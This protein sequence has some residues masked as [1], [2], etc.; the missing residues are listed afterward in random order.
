[1]PQRPGLGAP[2][3]L[4]GSGFPATSPRP[5][6]CDRVLNGSLD[7][8]HEMVER[9]E[10]LDMFAAFAPHAL[11]DL[12]VRPEILDGLAQR[13]RVVWGNEEAVDAIAQDVTLAV[14]AS[15]NDRLAHRHG[16]GHRGD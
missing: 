6:F 15:A 11:A 8:G 16:L 5:D 4:D 3:A 13:A 12:G 9:V 1:M 10:L 14:N 7:R 2:I